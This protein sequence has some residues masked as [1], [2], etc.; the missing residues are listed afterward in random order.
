MDEPYCCTCSGGATT[1]EKIQCTVP[2]A[3]CGCPMGQALTKA[4]GWTAACVSAGL[5]VAMASAR[6]VANAAP[7]TLGVLCDICAACTSLGFGAARC[8]LPAPERRASP[9]PTGRKP[10]SVGS[11]PDTRTELE[12]LRA[13]GQHDGKQGSAQ[14]LQIYDFWVKVLGALL[15]RKFHYRERTAIHH[16]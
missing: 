7:A 2:Q 11:D 1:S 8:A 13:R 15:S 4:G 10:R 16:R 14:H 3:S 12:G 6:D 9:Q 5:A